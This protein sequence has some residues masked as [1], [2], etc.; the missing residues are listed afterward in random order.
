MQSLGL[1]TSYVQQD[2]EHETGT[3][4]VSI[5]PAGQPNFTIKE[6][7]PG[8]SCNGRPEWEDLSAGLT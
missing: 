7:A 5:D 3:A 2:N 1:N 6:L 8:I 4:A